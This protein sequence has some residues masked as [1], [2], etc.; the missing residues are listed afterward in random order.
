MKTHHEL[1][2]CDVFLIG[3]GVVAGLFGKAKIFS[4]D[5]SRKRNNLKTLNKIGNSLHSESITKNNGPSYCSLRIACTVRTVC[6]TNHMYNTGDWESEQQAR[7]VTK[8][9][10]HKSIPI[11][12]FLYMLFKSMAV[13]ERT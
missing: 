6:K 5:T 9:G 8:R 4:D 11:V 2:V 7:E 13:R 1:E 10:V 3:Y 12:K